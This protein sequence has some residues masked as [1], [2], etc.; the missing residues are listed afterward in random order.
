[1]YQ[2]LASPALK[3]RHW[4]TLSEKTGSTIEPDEELTLQQLVDTNVGQHIET[5]HEVCVAAEKEYGLEK[6]LAAM[7]EEWASL[8]F[9]VRPYKETGT[10]LVSGVDEIVTLLDDHIVKTQT[11]RGSPYILPIEAECKAWEFRL[12]YAQGLVDEWISCQRTWLYLEPIFSSEDIMRQLPTEARRFNSVD[13]LWK[14]TMEETNKDPNFMAQA[15]VD[16]KLEEKF[17]AANQKLEEIQKG[18]SDYLEMKRLYFPRFFFL[19]NDELLEILSQTK[20]PR[21]VQPHLNKAFEGIAKCKFEEDLK[22]TE[23]VSAEGEIVVLDSAVDPESAANKGNVERWLL[24]LEAMQ[25]QSVRTQVTLSLNEYPT[26]PREEWVL[27]WP[28]QAVLG[29]S[30]VFWTQDVAASIKNGGVKGLEELV[31]SLN[32]QLRSITV[33]VRGRLSSLER[34]TLGALCTIDVHARDTV[35]KMIEAG[36]SHEDD[37]DWMSQLRYYWVEAWKDGQAVKKGDST[38]VARIVNAKCLY[39]YEYLG[40]TMRLV[41]T[42][43]TDRCYRTMIGAI[44]LLYGGA[45]EGPAGTGKTET[46]KDLSKAV[47]IQCVVFNCSDGLD[48]LAMAKFFKGLAGCGSWCCFDE[49]NRIN[50]EV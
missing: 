23:M 7:K 43:L 41:I 2:A 17:K 18:L 12:K 29:V 35:V 9:E 22:I 27:N 49:F 16:K 34:K 47:A 25:W 50:I 38:L 24:E 45:P 42:P 21:A 4:E 36:V 44:D 40:N 5:I 1:V 19:S 33:L 13:Q 14:K 31:Q 28:A 20:E 6:A 8:E 3:S 30:Q 32:Q 39:G 26:I 37:F 48:Y 11:M 10:F 46:V 15:D